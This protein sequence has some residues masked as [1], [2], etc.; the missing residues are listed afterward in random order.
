[1]GVS[2]IMNCYSYAAASFKKQKKQK[3]RQP[4]Q[5]L[6]DH[7]KHSQHKKIKCKCNIFQAKST[8]IGY[9]DVNG[10]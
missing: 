2:V 8:C 3:K 5:V 10:E 4:S 1:M 7:I 9:T 6:Y